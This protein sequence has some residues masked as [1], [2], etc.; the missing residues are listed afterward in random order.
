MAFNGASYRRNKWRRDALERLTEARRLKAHAASERDENG[1][2]W[3][4]GRVSMAVRL[5]RSSWRLYQLQRTVC[6][7]SGRSAAYRPAPWRTRP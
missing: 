5:A 7:L 1:R 3:A 6:E 4:L 2:Q